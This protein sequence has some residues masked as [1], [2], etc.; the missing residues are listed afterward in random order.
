VGKTFQ[1]YQLII[2]FSIEIGAVEKSKKF[3]QGRIIA[4]VGTL[5]PILI[6]GIV[7]SL[8]LT[9]FFSSGKVKKT[10]KIK[11]REKYFDQNIMVATPNFIA[12]KIFF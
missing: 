4:V 9:E 11:R 3:W 6:L 1:I 2:L 5:I 7:K 12:M 10:N 8:E